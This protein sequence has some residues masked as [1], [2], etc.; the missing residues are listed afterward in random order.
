MGIYEEGFITIL[1]G[2]FLFK[3]KN[4]NRRNERAC[5]MVLEVMY[6]KRLDYFKKIDSIFC[7]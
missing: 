5:I 4:L 3:R 1:K 6:L 7:Y 2:K